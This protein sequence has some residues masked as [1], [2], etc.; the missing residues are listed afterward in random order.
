[1]RELKLGED[2]MKTMRCPKAAKEIVSCCADVPT[3]WPGHG[4]NMWTF[5]SPPGPPSA[6]KRSA[7]SR[8]SRS[9]GVIDDEPID[10]SLAR[11]FLGGSGLAATLTAVTVWG[12]SPD[13]LMTIGHRIAGL[14]PLINVRRGVGVADD[15]LPTVFQAPLDAGEMLGNVPDAKELLTGRTPSSSGTR[16]PVDRPMTRSLAAC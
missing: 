10:A 11:S 9:A 7:R 12:L 15:V 3:E 2:L 1:M 16:A 8:R 6:R 13:A 5:V 14:K 4:S